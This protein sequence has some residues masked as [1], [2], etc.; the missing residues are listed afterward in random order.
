M[1]N[2]QIKMNTDKLD[3]MIGM[4]LFKADKVD[5]PSEYEK[6]LLKIE[7]LVKLRTEIGDSK[8]KESN[9]VAIVSGA[10]QIASILIVLQYE[11]ANVITSKAYSIASGMFGKGG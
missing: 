5:D 9:K 8:A 7:R 4:L 11:K 3:V 6:M 2:K 10:V 1:F